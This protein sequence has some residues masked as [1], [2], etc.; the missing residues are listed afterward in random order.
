MF[1]GLCSPLLRVRNV[2]TKYPV[3]FRLIAARGVFFEPA[4]NIGIQ[5]Y[6]HRLLD[7][8]IKVASASMPPVFR[9]CFRNIGGVDA[10][11][12]LGL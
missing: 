11:I 3:D 10:L 9:W 6:S 7:R 1:A 4:D 5:S 12:R 2:S 8:T